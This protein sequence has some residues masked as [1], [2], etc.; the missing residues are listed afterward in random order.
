[1]PSKSLPKEDLSVLQGH[2]INTF[3]TEHGEKVLLHLMD[4]AGI[5]KYSADATHEALL[6]QKGSQRLV[7]SI[8]SILNTDPKVILERAQHNQTRRYTDEIE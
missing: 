8:L 1:M 7:F 6:L 2:Y 5:T 3:T 4:Q